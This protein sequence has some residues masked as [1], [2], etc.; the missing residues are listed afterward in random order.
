MDKKAI[1]TFAIQARRDLIKSI[2]LKME[3]LG[4]NE[5]GV[6]EKSAAST[7]EI[8]YYG[9]KGLFISGQDIK[10]RRDLVSRLKTMAKQEEWRDAFSDLIEEV[11]Y[12]WF[13]RIIAIRFME[14]NDY[15]P[16]GVRVLSSGTKLKVPDILREAFNIEDE[17]G[18]Y[19]S[20]ERAII[21]KAL[22]TEELSDMDAAYVILFTKQANA[23]NQY[24]PELFEKTDDFMQLL[25]TPSYSVG[26]FVILWMIFVKMILM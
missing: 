20:D 4:I 7:S 12:T 9:D 26:S 3:N 2:R 13:N 8:E 19:S 5:N 22:D 25:F 17:L 15:L 16:S 6:E 18:G 23:L 14:V 1:K 21:Q 10:R 11:A 24:L